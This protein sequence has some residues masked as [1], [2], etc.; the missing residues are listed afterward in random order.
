MVERL[1]ISKDQRFQSL[2][3]KNFYYVC[4]HT[5]EMDTPQPICNTCGIDFCG[6]EFFLCTDDL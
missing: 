2:A 3:A 1:M 4:L 5:F 6:M